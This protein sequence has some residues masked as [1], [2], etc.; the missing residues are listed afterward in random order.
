[1]SEEATAQSETTTTPEANTAP[2]KGLL[3]TKIGMTRVFVDDTRM[4]PVTVVT[5][6]NLVV[7]QVKTK[8]TD[9]YDAVQVGYGDV[10]ERKLSKAEVGH[11][12]KKNVGPKRFAHEFR[13]KDT[14]EFKV[15][16]AVPV[17]VFSKGDWVQVSG[18]TKGKGYAGVVKR[19]GFAGLP[20]SHGNG[21]YRNHPGSSGAQGPQHVLPGTRKPGHMGHVWSTVPRMEVVDVDT[22]KNLILLR[23]SVPEPNSNFVGL[24]AHL[25]GDISAAAGVQ[26]SS[27][28]RPRSKSSPLS[29]A[30]RDQSDFM[31]LK[32]IN[33]TGQESG[34][35]QFDEALVAT[36]A[37][38]AVLHEVVVAYLAGL[39][40]GT[41]RTKTR[42]EVSGGGI[43]PWK[44]KHT[45]NSRSGSN[46]SPLWRKGGIIFGPV[47]RDYSVTIPKKKKHLAFRMAMKSLLDN[48][49]IQVVDPIE[50]NRAENQESSR[51]CSRSGKRRPIRFSSPTKWTRCS[52]A[53]RASILNGVCA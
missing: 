12:K 52:I 5:A 32:I 28:P 31:E 13:V 33:N 37:S 51:P 49:K 14:S 39:R 35:V 42:A 40:S 22:E 50:I 47:P 25:R 20:H 15:G 27:K 46:R 11:F 23:G 9:G 7:T 16:Q 36:R 44:Q 6:E 2:L 3:G 4:V 10:G 48:N 18:L 1:M 26:A 19:H 30:A 53:P 38:Q 17:S 41:H 45:G 24:E 21:E 34:A 43:K 29:S 8:I